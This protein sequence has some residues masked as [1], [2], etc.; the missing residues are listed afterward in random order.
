M[1]AMK[2]E[3][4]S[5]YN[6]LK[7]LVTSYAEELSS[8]RGGLAGEVSNAISSY[9]DINFGSWSDDVSSNL[10]T[11]CNT[12]KNGLSFVQSDLNEGGYKSISLAL[13]DLTS[14]LKECQ[15]YRSRINNQSDRL[16]WSQTKTRTEEI[17]SL[18]KAE[19]ENLKRC[20]AY[21][22]G[23]ID[24]LPN[25]K[26]NVDSTYES[27]GGVVAGLEDTT[28]LLNASLGEEEDTSTQSSRYQ[29]PTDAW[30]FKKDGR[31]YYC[32]PDPNSEDDF[33]IYDATN[34]QEVGRQSMMSV[35]TEYQ[36]CSEAERMA[37]IGG[38]TQSGN[39]NGSVRPENVPRMLSTASS[40]DRSTWQRVDSFTTRGDKIEN[41]TTTVQGQ[42][43]NFSTTKDGTVLHYDVEIDGVMHFYDA[44]GSEISV[45]K[46][47]EIRD[48]Y[49]NS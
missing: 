4:N 23:I 18:I 8:A 1:C 40:R 41:Y 2:V 46:R 43:V 29:C 17:K 6:Q 33:V 42:V 37:L 10:N 12:V 16:R 20:V 22:N 25:I 21:C 32:Y 36:P 48:N 45:E 39:P 14:G 19:Q 26:F 24:Q 13:S 28:D 7:S 30:F 11:Y 5:D 27:T 34:G 3:I 44:D 15:K 38:G 9:S 49:N 31:Y 47:Q 35:T